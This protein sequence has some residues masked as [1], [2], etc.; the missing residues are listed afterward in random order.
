MPAGSSCWQE[1]SDKL[2]CFVFTYHYY[3]GDTVTWS[4][5]CDGGIAVGRGV[6]RFSRPEYP[7]KSV[8][9]S[10]ELVQGKKHGHWVIKWSNDTVWEGP[11]VDGKRHGRWVVKEADGSTSE[12]P[13]VDGERHGR[14]VTTFASGTTKIHNWRNGE[15][16]D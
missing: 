6:L 4:G 12:G 7:D 14:W 9:Y 1:I 13:M 10:G 8:D 11:Y 3:P 15:L 5:G 16:V 2:R